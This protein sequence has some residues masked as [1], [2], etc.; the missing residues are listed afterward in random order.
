MGDKVREAEREAFEAWFK[1]R[2]KKMHLERC[3]E[4]YFSDWAACAWEG[5]QARASLAAPPQEQAP[6]WVP[7]D[8]VVTVDEVAWDGF[9]ADYE[10]YAAGD[11]R[12]P[13]SALRQSLSAVIDSA[14]RKPA[15]AQRQ[16]PSELRCPKCEL[17]V[18]SSCGA[19]CPVPNRWDEPAVP[20]QEQAKGRV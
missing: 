1:P 7:I 18:L 19:G 14:R 12:M 6:G 8:G 3:G 15:E 2:A 13:F 20:S 17:R 16:E 4:T 11:L 10:K 5:W 9:I